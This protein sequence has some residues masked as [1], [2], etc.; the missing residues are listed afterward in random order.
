MIEPYPD[1]SWHQNPTKGCSN[2]IVSVFRV[3][4]S[5]F[6]LALQENSRST[7]EYRWSPKETSQVKLKIKLSELQI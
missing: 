7:V 4:V 1:Y 3:A 2:K 5:K 6:S